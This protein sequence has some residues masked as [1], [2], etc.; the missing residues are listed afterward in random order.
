[1][2]LISNTNHDEM[3][4][5]KFHLSQNYPNPFKEKTIIKYCIAFKT[6]VSITVSD[7]ENKLIET[8]VQEEKEAGTYELTWNAENLPSGVYF[9]QLKAGDFIST[10]KMILLK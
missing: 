4:P 10:K 3:I 7:F 9:Y 8:L 1:M 6:K 5:S 2:N